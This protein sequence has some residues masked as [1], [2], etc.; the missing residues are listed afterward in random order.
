MSIALPAAPAFGAPVEQHPCPE[1]LNF[2]ATRRSSSAV[3]LAEPAPSDDEVAQL[4]RL[5]ARAPDHGKLAPWRFVIL[6]GEDKAAY[7][8]RLEALAQSRG[9]TRAAAKL[10]KLK[11]PPM[12]IAVISAPRVHEI[13]EWEQVLSAGAVCTGLLY[14]AQALGYGANWITDWY[15]YDGE[16]KA[17]LGLAPGESVAGFIFIGTAKESPMERERPDSQAL[18]TVWKP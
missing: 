3:T 14:A 7:A 17:I 8:A 9:D 1:L 6:R 15:A 5:A 13:P 18:T 16:A 2:L 11:L 10:A 12:G 4:I